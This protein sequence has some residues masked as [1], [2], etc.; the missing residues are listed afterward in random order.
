[1]LVRAMVSVNA[2]RQSRLSS[3]AC[4]GMVNSAVEPQVVHQ[5]GGQIDDD[6]VTTEFI[7]IDVTFDNGTNANEPAAFGPLHKD[8]AHIADPEIFEEAQHTAGLNQARKAAK[9]SVHNIRLKI[10]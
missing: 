10:V 1:M 4:W 9:N 5:G 8:A 2:S 6:R 3:L 7:A